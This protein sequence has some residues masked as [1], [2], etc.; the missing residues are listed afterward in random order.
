MIK[1][2]KNQ[3][4]LLFKNIIQKVFYINKLNMKQIKI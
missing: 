2:N 3:I 1:K 4:F